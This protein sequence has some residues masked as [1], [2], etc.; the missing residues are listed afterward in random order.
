MVAHRLERYLATCKE[1]EVSPDPAVIAT[2]K[3]NSEYLKVSSSKGHTAEG[4]WL[5]LVTLM[6]SPVEGEARTPSSLL[7]FKPIRQPSVEPQTK[8]PKEMHPITHLDISPYGV[9]GENGGSL[10]KTLLTHNST[11]THLDVCASNVDA[12]TAEAI[13]EALQ[14]NTT[15]INL[16]LEDNTLGQ[17]GA[18]NLA[19]GLLTAKET[20]ALLELNV[21]HTASTFHGVTDIL[22]AVRE[23]N[24][25]RAEIAGEG[26]EPALLE[27]DTDRNFTKEEIAN[28][29]SHGIGVILALFGG[30]FLL[31][32]AYARSE[33]DGLAC[34]VF[35][36]SML[37]CY[38]SSSLYHGMFTLKRVQKILKILDHSAIY[39]LIAGT[40]TPMVLINFEGVPYGNY[41]L[42]LQWVVAFVGIVTKSFDASR[43][44]IQAFELTLF[45]LMGWSAL[46]FLPQL[47]QEEEYF[48]NLAVL[49]GCMYTFGI[50]FFIRGDI[51][52]MY[53]AVWHLFVM[54]GGLCHFLAIYHTVQTLPIPGA[55]VVPYCSGQ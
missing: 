3:T 21:N 16:H 12:R 20:T 37:T 46:F 9:A 4:R 27:V 25:H 39:L 29:V 7:H 1:V 38:I 41:L 36:L 33:K 45:A 18:E 34:T 11:I 48:R 40:Y 28:S 52:P 14:E 47:L 5:A 22:N 49:G 15:L 35:I 17:D 54:A 53:H 42:L 43:E 6:V 55:Q 19:R 51:W 10:L 32:K 24:A 44:E 30:S 31:P 23:V 26:N 50:F 13:A 8:A 2:L